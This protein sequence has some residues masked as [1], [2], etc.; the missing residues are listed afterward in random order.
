MLETIIP[1]IIGL[2]LFG[3]L[4]IDTK[5]KKGKEEI[6]YY[7][8]NAY[9][10]DGKFY[11]RFRGLLSEENIY[12]DTRLISSFWRLTHWDRVSQAVYGIK[13]F[14]ADVADCITLYIIK[15]LNDQPSCNH[16]GHYSPDRE[17]RRI[18]KIFDLTPEENRQLIQ[19]SLTAQ[20]HISG[21]FRS[22][23]SGGIYVY[24]TAS[25]TDIS[26][27]IFPNGPQTEHSRTDL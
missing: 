6:V 11:G 9:P 26:G 15:L 22:S 20:N 19:D 8:S 13:I 7:T 4:I 23:P 10:G 16:S 24:R 21:M 2:L 17:P 14:E 25:P 5:P 12:K 3:W 18:N 1:L 27:E